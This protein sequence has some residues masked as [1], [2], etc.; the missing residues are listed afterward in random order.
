MRVTNWTAFVFIKCWW[1]LL[2][3]SILFLPSHVMETQLE[4][5]NH[6][7]EVGG[8]YIREAR[9]LSYNDHFGKTNLLLDLWTRAIPSS[10]SRSTQLVF[11]YKR[12]WLHLN[13]FPLTSL[14]LPLF[15][16]TFNLDLWG[17]GEGI[18]FRSTPVRLQKT[19]SQGATLSS[20]SY[21]EDHVKGLGQ[22]G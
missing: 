15:H 19:E 17:G 6:S 11:I 2:V 18:L 5:L 3:Q 16:W 14:F 13:V 9:H 1:N 4:K 21:T 7:L 20:A 12:R 8:P 10:L 22:P